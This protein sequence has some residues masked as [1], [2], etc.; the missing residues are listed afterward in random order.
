MGGESIDIAA[1][2]AV[3][4]TVMTVACGWPQLQ[5]L[6]HTGDV[7]GISFTTTTLS[8]SSELG[9][10]MYL[11]GEGLWSALPETV[12]TIAVDVVLTLALV[13]AGA[14]WVGA[15]GTASAWGAVLAGCMVIG[16]APAMAVALSVTYA[17]QLVPSVWAAW[18]ARCPS[19]VAP[20]AW[21]LRLIQS[22]L[23]G[24]YGYMRHD[25]P[26]LVLGVIGS[27]AS[28]AVLARLF[29]IRTRVAWA[30]ATVVELSSAGKRVGIDRYGHGYEYEGGVGG[31]ERAA[32]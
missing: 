30:P 2:I 10:L 25:Q 3:V 26:L 4:A 1:A 19:G 6:R 14:R 12:L 9:W 5:R 11:A 32:A 31:V 29:L 24:V 7:R 13:R 22:V 16:G 27:V 18:R 15:A 28:V 21:T 8:I 17:V 23:W 20:A